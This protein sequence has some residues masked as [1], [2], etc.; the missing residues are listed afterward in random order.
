LAKACGRAGFRSARFGGIESLVVG[1]P[2][3]VHRL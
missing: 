1:E 2:H 3:I